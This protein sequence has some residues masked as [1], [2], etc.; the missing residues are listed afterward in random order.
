M[1]TCVFVC[2]R[3]YWHGHALNPELLCLS[4]T[5]AKGWCLLVKPSGVFV[6]VCLGVG[7]QKCGYVCG[8][9]VW[10]QVRVWVWC[11]GG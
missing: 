10:V 9:G 11:V 1:Y 8:Y 5:P 3:G 6:H 2:V 4:L 7:G